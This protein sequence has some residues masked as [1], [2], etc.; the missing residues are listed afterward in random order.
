VVAGGKE[1]AS[2]V[3]EDHSLRLMHTLQ[4]PKARMRT[5]MPA[6][7]RPPI[8]PPLRPR[9]VTGWVVETGADAKQRVSDVL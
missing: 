6:T 2:D 9:L 3:L 5:K 1:D 8:S 7:A 4:V